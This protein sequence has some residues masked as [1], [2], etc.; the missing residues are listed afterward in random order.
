[1]KFRPCIDLHAGVVK[2]I[3]GSTFSDDAPSTISTNYSSAR[4]ASWYAGMY[5][6][7]GLA[8][9]H[10][11]KL[12]PGN[13]EAAAE[14]LEAFPGGFHMPWRPFPAGFTS[15]GGSAGRTPFPGSTAGPPT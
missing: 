15:G 6:R 4:P 1:M 2:Q 11:I 13:D 3:V 5:R 10:V 8:A 7:D 14:A 9:G 12:G